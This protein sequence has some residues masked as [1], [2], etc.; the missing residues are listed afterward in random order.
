MGFEILECIQQRSF[1]I[2]Q[3]FAAAFVFHRHQ[4]MKFKRI[5]SKVL[6]FFLREAGEMRVF[7]FWFE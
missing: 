1:D 6:L 3:Q 7:R 4:I 5:L 2:S